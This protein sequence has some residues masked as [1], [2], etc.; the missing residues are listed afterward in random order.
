MPRSAWSH[1]GLPPVSSA[2]QSTP[3]SSQSINLSITCTN[4]LRKAEA[5]GC[6]NNNALFL[7]PTE[8]VATLALSMRPVDAIVRGSASVRNEG[9]LRSSRV[10]RIAVLLSI[11]VFAFGVC[12]QTFKV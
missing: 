10:I 6:D 2:S 1:E 7:E 3:T 9:R 5:S 4:S 11:I 12:R 8:P